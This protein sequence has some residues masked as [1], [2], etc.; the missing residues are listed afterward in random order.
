[1]AVRRLNYTGRRRLGQSDARVFIQTAE[2]QPPTFGA[3]L[4]LGE[5]DLPADAKVFVEAYRQTSFMR[6]PCGT[7]GAFRLPDDR[8]LRE[9][10]SPE[11][12]L[13]RVRI[14]S[15]TAPEGLLLAEADALR[16]GLTE[17]VEQ[18][19]IS[20]LPIRSH[21][22]GHQIFR[23]DFADR[24]VL[25]VNSRVG[26]WRSASLDPVFISLVF[27]AAMR[28]ILTRILHIEKYFEIEESD[29]WE[30]QWL[31]F[32]VAFP[33]VPDVP[34]DDKD[35]IDDWVDEAVGAFCRDRTI[36]ARFDQYLTGGAAS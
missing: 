5:Y 23:V 10:D 25:L 28:E 3:T 12:V 24:P 26:D 18:N 36:Y 22:L 27:P 9:F 16:P 6:F 15:S 17:E 13:F 32:C 2:G 4:T 20:L 7:V 21:D 29:R 8:H 30:S 33:G 35:K 34:P 11:G 31:K 14:T 19:S 1:M